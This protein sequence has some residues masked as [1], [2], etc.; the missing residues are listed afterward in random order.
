MILNRLIVAY[1]KREAIP[2][3]EEGQPFFRELQKEA[4]A[5]VQELVG[6][7]P[8]AAQ[9]IWTSPLQLR[10][11]ERFQRYIDTPVRPTP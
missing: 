4:M 5:N 10:V 9:R 8:E 1:C 6:Q 7:V 11:S 3:K 2:W